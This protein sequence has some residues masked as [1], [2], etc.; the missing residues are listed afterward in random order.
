M[1]L[2]R[3]RGAWRVR[4]CGRARKGVDPGK[5]RKSRGAGGEVVSIIGVLLSEDHHG[6]A[7]SWGMV[8]S[9]GQA[10]MFVNTL[11]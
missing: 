4:S 1:S 10:K 6:V 3:E 11:V 9:I 5:P 2:S 7:V 8:V